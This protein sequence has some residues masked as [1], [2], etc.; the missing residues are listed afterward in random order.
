M[1]SK[2]RPV[3]AFDVYNMADTGGIKDLE[4]DSD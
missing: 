3:I 4:L 1:N 2:D